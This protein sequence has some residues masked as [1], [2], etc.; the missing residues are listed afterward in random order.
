MPRVLSAAW[1]FFGPQ[2]LDR[3]TDNFH[4]NVHV[5]RARVLEQGKV[6]L[7]LPLPLP[8]QEQYFISATTRGAAESSWGSSHAD[9]H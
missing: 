7:P 1:H 9:C 6:L 4:G 3:M 8:L 2:L 5:V